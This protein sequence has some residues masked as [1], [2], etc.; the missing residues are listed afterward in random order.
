MKVPFLDLKKQLDPIRDQVLSAITEVVDSTRYILG[1]KVEELEKEIAKYCGSKYAVG[2]SSGTDALLVSLMA[3]G[4]KRGDIVITTPY[5]FFA[6]AGVIA[7]LNAQVIFVDI[8]YDSFNIDP[9]KLRKVLEEG[10]SGKITRKPFDISRVKAII[11]VHLFGRC[12]NMEKI[13]EISSK[14]SIPIIEDAAQAIGS[15]YFF[16]G[17]VKKAGTMSNLGCFSFFPS[18]N[19]GCMGDGGMVVTDNSRLAEKLK[20]LRVHGGKPKYFHSIV[21]GN[22]RLDPLQA[23]ILKIKLP[24]LD[25]WNRVRRANAWDYTRLFKST[26]IV[27]P[28][29]ENGHIFNQYVIRVTERDSLRMF[30]REREVGTEVY[31]PVPFHLQKCFE[32]IGYKDGDFPESETASEESLALPIFP[33]LTLDQQRYVV[34]CI[35]DFKERR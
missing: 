25:K 13:I 31:Y 32:Y 19:L 6:T 35:E 21:G 8:E 4:V 26:N 23:A 11:P 15:E 9:D 33:E 27:I 22:F 20:V 30:L 34:Q 7:R 14:Y 29:I 5:S 28:K 17:E 1:P 18:K 2:V 12:A 24:F 10:S 16:K 3:L